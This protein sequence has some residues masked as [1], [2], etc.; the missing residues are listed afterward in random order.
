MIAARAIASICC[1]FACIAILRT[2]ARS[3]AAQSTS[4][5]SAHM[6][7]PGTDT[8]EIDP[9]ATLGR[10]WG[11][12][13]LHD[14]LAG[15]QIKGK[16][17]FKRDDPTAFLQNNALGIELTFRRIDALDVPPRDPPPGAFVL[18][19]IRFYG[20][21]SKTHAAFKG[22]LP[23]GLRFGDNREAMITKFG[24]PDREGTPIDQTQMR[25]DTQRYALFTHRDKAGGLDELSL[26]VPFVASDKP[27][28]EGR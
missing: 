24:P 27:G 8:M 12:R 11:E 2:D 20:P 26:Q 13:E 7:V 25:W 1:I 17:V 23:F 4:P 9:I 19:N 6:R 5:L 15:F 21:G 14:F 3:A 18:S 22:D 10:A 16:P 28:F